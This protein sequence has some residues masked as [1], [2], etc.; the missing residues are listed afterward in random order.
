MPSSCGLMHTSSDPLDI[1]CPKTHS[2]SPHTQDT[3]EET[4]KY[5]L[6]PQRQRQCRGNHN[7][8]GVRHV[9]S[10]ELVGLPHFHSVDRNCE[11]GNGQDTSHQQ[12][13]FKV[14]VAEETVQQ[15]IW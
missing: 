3:E 2:S 9:E 15:G 1:R 6:H 10:A 14:D 7:S 5:S 12:T 13:Q 8:Q 11:S 4:G